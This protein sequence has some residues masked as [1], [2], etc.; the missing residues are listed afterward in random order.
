MA[1]RNPKKKICLK[2]LHEAITVIQ[3]LCPNDTHPPLLIPTVCST[4]SLP[5]IGFNNIITL[6]ISGQKRELKREV[7]AILYTKT[8]ESRHLHQEGDFKYGIAFFVVTPIF[9]KDIQQHLSPHII[10]YRHT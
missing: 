4:K 3:F 9:L 2:P 8:A 7:E 5:P 1:L 10:I 6:L